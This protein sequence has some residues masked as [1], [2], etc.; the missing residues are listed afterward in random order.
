MVLG[1]LQVHCPPAQ[2]KDWLTWR[3]WQLKFEL[4]SWQANRGAEIFFPLPTSPCASAEQTRQRKPPCKLSSA[5][6]W[7]WAHRTLKWL[8]WFLTRLWPEVVSRIGEVLSL[9]VCL[10]TEVPDRVWMWSPYS[11]GKES[12][13]II[14]VVRLCVLGTET[15][16]RSQQSLQA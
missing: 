14:D 16:N 3:A 5:W 2:W 6:V 15:K 13:V 7:T 11:E 8:K 4:S 1:S 10:G 9:G 12:L